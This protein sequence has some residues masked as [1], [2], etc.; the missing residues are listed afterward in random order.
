MY[1]AEYPF[2]RP[3]GGEAG[4]DPVFLGT[5]AG[6]RVDTLTDYHL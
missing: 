2:L 1:Y 4:G 6:V 3:S 5:L